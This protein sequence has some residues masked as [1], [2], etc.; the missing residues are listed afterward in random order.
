LEA[1]SREM[2][3]KALT[4]GNVTATLLVDRVAAVQSIR[5]N[6]DVLKD[7]VSAADQA[8][9]IVGGTRPTVAE[10]MA[11]R[12]VLEI[13]DASTLTDESRAARD[14][15][16]LSCLRASLDA[17]MASRRGE[18]D[19]LAATLTSQIALIETITRDVR[20]SPSRTRDAVLTRLK[21]QIERLQSSADG[22]DPERLL[23]EAVLIATKVDV[24]EELARLDAHVQAAREMM[25]E[26]A[27]V[28]RKLDFLAQEFNR[29]ANTLCSKANAVDVTRLGLALKSVIDQFREQVQNVE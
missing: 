20:L 5:L 14:G 22:L 11:M 15:A 4:R 18:G 19:R 27:S 28:G 7:V 26:K 10:Y 23:Q 12:G 16:V 17:L 9:A 25:Q 8:V 24:E 13:G 2:I 6:V 29:E 1:A 3:T 21:E